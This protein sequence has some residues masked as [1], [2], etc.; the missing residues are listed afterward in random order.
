MEVNNRPLYEEDQVITDRQL[1]QMLQGLVYQYQ[2]TRW[3]DWV[4]R[5]KIRAS[6][7][8]IQAMISWMKNGKPTVRLHQGE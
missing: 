5:L 1:A 8:C 3:W 2:Y 4:E 7:G 6:I